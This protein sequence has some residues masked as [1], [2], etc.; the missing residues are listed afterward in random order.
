MRRSKL[1][2]HM[3]VRGLAAIAIAG[4]IIFAA[5]VVFQDIVQYDYLIAHGDDPRTTSPISINRLGPYGWIQ[6]ANF[7]VIGI[8]V[9]AL[10]VAAHRG[11]RGAG[12]SGLGPAFIAIWGVAWLLGMFPIE[13]HVHTF[14]GYM[15]GVA[16]LLLSVGAV[17]M[18]LF[19]WRRL[20]TSP[21]WDGFARYTLGMGLLTA[22][23]W[24]ASLA[25]QKVVPLS[26]FYVWVTAVLL[27]CVLLGVRIWRAAPAESDH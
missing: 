9:L 15:H 4:P 26:W 24:A 21:G 25:F 18:F 1:G 6:E 27:W 8:S 12:R 23:L 3:N 11:I 17:P 14:S 16:F 22:P 20:R 10:A 5:A 19:M 7:A 13:R 2:R